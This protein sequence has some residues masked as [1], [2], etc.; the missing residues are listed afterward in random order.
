MLNSQ[1]IRTLAPAFMRLT[2][3]RDILGSNFV[4]ITFI[5]TFSLYDFPSGRLSRKHVDGEKDVFLSRFYFTVPVINRI[6]SSLNN[7]YK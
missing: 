3:V 1:T 2:C 5:L 7:F 4:L 6:Y